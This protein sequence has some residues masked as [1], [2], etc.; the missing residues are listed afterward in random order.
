M[1][2]WQKYGL[3]FLIGLAAVWAAWNVGFIRKIVF[4]TTTTTTATE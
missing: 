3:I 1:K 4:K 2:T